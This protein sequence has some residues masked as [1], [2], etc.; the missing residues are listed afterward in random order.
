MTWESEPISPELALVCPELRRAAIAA[1]A[2][3]DSLALAQA[4]IAVAQTTVRPVST[5][6]SLLFRLIG[7]N[8]L[9]AFLAVWTTAVFTA[10]A[11]L[12]R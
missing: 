12:I 8:L 1:D 9:L 10:V 6:P 2:W 5:P 11:D 7:L 4:G 3:G